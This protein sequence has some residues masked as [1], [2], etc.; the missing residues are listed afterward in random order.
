MSCSQSRCSSA[1]V[2]SVVC[3][4]R[5]TSGLAL[6]TITRAARSTLPAGCIQSHGASLA[7]APET[8]LGRPSSTPCARR[9]SPGATRPGARL[10]QDD[11][12]AAFGISRIPLREALRRLEGEGLVVISPN[13]GAV[14]QPAGAE[15]RRRPLRSA[16]R[17]RV[18]CVTPCR[19]ALCRPARVDASAPRAGAGGDRRP[20]PDHALP[21][22]PRLPRRP[23]RR[24]RQPAPGRRARRA[25][26]ADH[27]R[28]AR[29]LRG[30]RLS[31]RHVG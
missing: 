27:A 4:A 16:P 29:L 24:V 25:V 26:V 11:L 20:E 13:R 7:R 17:A 8:P 15:R 18:T 31:S 9:S 3:T 6:Y 28:D 21:A 12:A 14:V 30:R 2:F 19:R 22:R 23:R 1:M 5:A 10:V